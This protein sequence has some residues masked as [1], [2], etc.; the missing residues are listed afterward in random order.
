M[1]NYLKLMQTSA[2]RNEV[3]RLGNVLAEDR[4]TNT[5]KNNKINEKD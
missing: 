2:A 3:D 4:C 1:N 5:N